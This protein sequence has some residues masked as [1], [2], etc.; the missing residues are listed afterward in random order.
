MDFA[1]GDKRNDKGQSSRVNLLQT[2]SE[3]CAGTDCATIWATQ[4]MIPGIPEVMNIICLGVW[5]P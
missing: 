5:H 1:S 4:N 2:G 3:R